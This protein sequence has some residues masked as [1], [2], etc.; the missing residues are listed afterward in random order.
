VEVEYTDIR[1]INLGNYES[2]KIGGTIRVN[3]ND[4]DE[5]ERDEIE[6]EHMLERCE[7]AWDRW[8]LP[9]IA[10]LRPVAAKDSHVH[11]LPLDGR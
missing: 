1:T 11:K 5:D 6:P 3:L 10:E 9:R 2:A 8:F 4:F 7:T